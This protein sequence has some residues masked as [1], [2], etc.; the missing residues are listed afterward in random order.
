MVVTDIHKRSTTMIAILDFGR[1]IPD[2]N[3][4]T[5]WGTHATALVYPIG[6]QAAQ[7]NLTE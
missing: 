7:I 5:K 6:I 2:E 1:V 3:L 4:F